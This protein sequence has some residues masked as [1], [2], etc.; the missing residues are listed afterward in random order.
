MN[1]MIL[2]AGK[3]SRM[4]SLSRYMQ[5]CMYPVYDK[6]FLELVLESVI[7]NASFDASKDAVVLVTGYLG[8][9]VRGYFGTAWLDVPLR[10]A[11]QEHALGTAHAVMA[12]AAAAPIGQSCIVIQGDVW[13][14]PAFLSRLA[15]M[16]GENVLSII[17]YECPL[18]HDERVDVSHG[19]VTRAWQGSS[20]YVECGTWKF[21]PE[22]LGFMMSRKA[23]EYRALASVHNAI[24]HGLPV[25]ALERETWVHLGGTEPSVPENLASLLRFFSQGAA[26]WS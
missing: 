21:S 22:M 15:G 1:Y 10:Y 17:R 2:A 20:P 6:P 16:D 9:Q 4:G 19:L 14:E 25:V 26:S 11:V 13:V 24:E 8:E 3:G 7:R 12:G 23:D 18:R 5:K